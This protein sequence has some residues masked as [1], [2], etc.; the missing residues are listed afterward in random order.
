MITQAEF[1]DVIEQLITNGS[2]FIAVSKENLWREELVI[3]YHDQ[4]ENLL[5][6][7]GV[8]VDEVL[9]DGT[10]YPVT[11]QRVYGTNV[12]FVHR[13]P[14]YSQGVH[15]TPEVTLEEGIENIHDQLKTGWNPVESRRRPLPFKEFAEELVEAGA[16]K[17]E[18]DKESFRDTDGTLFWVR[19]YTKP[20]RGMPIIKLTDGVRFGDRGYLV[21][22]LCPLVYLPT[23]EWSVVVYADSTDPVSKPVSL[24]RG[25]ENLQAYIEKEDSIETF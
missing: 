21:D 19:A 12:H 10:V 20:G 16:S 14:I 2:S 9:L 13:V 4:V 22:G 23:E 1:R 15:G 3:L 17:I 5:Q 6:P 11:C 7:S 24:E 25:V 18:I 8:D